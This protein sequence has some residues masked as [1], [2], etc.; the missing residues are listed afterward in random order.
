MK[1][2]DECLKQLSIYNR[3]TGYNL[4]N[5]ETALAMV[6]L[7]PQDEPIKIEYCLGSLKVKREVIV[8]GIDEALR[9]AQNK[10][11]DFQ[12]ALN[13]LCEVYKVEDEVK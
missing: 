13:Q 6:A 1:T 5:L 8:S 9:H 10:V 3:V 12:V 7:T 11:N 4:E 2:T